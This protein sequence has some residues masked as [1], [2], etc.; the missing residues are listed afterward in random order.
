[1]FQEMTRFDLPICME[2]TL[3]TPNK[4]LVQYFA[5]S[6]GACKMLLSMAGCACVDD[7]TGSYIL[8]RTGAHI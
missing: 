5:I 6:Y 3:M 4:A 8:R 2:D 7:L 1:M